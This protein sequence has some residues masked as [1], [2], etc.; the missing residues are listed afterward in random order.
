[1]CEFACDPTDNSRCPDGGNYCSSC[2]I[3]GAT[4]RRR[5]FRIEINGGEKISFP[6]NGAINIKPS[7]RSHGWFFEPGVVGNLEMK[8][9]PLDEKFDE[10]LVLTPLIIA[11]NWGGIGAKTQLGYGVVEITNPPNVSFENFKRV[12]RNLSQKGKR[13]KSNEPGFPNLKDMFFAKVRFKANGNCWEKIDGLI[14]KSSKSRLEKEIRKK[15][16]EECFRNNFLPIAPVIKNWLRYDDGSQIWKPKNGTTKGIENWLFGTIRNICPKCY[17]IVNPQNENGKTVY[18]CQ[19]CGQ[20]F[21]KEEIINKCASKIN[22]SCAYKIGN[23]LW[24]IRIWGWIPKDAPQNFPREEFLDKLK[25]VL[26]TGIAGFLGNST[27]DH[28]LAVWRE[29]ASKRDTIKEEQNF[30]NFVES[31]LR[32]TDDVS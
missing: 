9:I 18:E 15:G 13:Q 26:Q 21:K 17:N 31:L 11:S 19:N 6:G 7:G 2:L 5:L 32:G 22:I 23:D 12:L 8:M 1:M 29:Y 16:I 4:G 24:E 14:D 10:V 28:K 25:K 27:S 20:K 3:F 30:D